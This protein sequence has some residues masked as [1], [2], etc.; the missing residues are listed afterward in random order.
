MM[1]AWLVGGAD[2]IQSDIERR[3]ADT[4]SYK[5][6]ALDDK[7]ALFLTTAVNNLAATHKTQFEHLRPLI[8][9]FISVGASIYEHHHTMDVS[10]KASML[11]LSDIELHSVDLGGA[12]IPAALA[13]A[14]RLCAQG[15][16]L[17]LIAGAE[18]PR[19]GPTG[20][21]YYR[22]ISDALLHKHTELHTHTNLISLYALMADR[23]IFEEGVTVDDV[24]AIT[25]YYRSAAVADPRAAVHGK[26]FREGELRR[27]LAGCYATPMVAVATDHG[28]A[29][30][31]ASDN[32]LKQLPTAGFALFSPLAIRGVGTNSAA[33]YLTQ[34]PNFTSPAGLAAER[35]FTR[36]GLTAGDIDYAWI[37]DCF[38]LMLVRQAAD[39]FDQ[40]AETVAQT[41][42]K[43]YLQ[44][45][46][47][48]IPVNSRGGI[49]NT[50]AAISLSAAS[51]LLDI[52][53]YARQNAEAQNFFFGG[54]G[55]IDTIN[56]VALLS[57]SGGI[58]T[59]GTVSRP[60]VPAECRAAVDGEE[61]RL[62]AAVMVR[63]NPGTDVPFALGA[64]RR[65]D[66]SLFLARMLD[67]A[68][69]TPSDT[70]RYPRDRALFHLRI[71]EAG[72]FAVAAP[73]QD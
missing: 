25:R 27:Y 45:G 32:M 2:A 61:A 8:T 21:A 70:D 13:T 17:V 4:Q 10:K 64:F 42:R 38:T 20:V 33:K 73:P 71:T 51:G 55:G 14:Q 59:A 34:R 24:E 43:G 11:G 6:L 28:A 72:V 52:L 47:K 40:K 68:G 9:D 53:D 5:K 15:D 65:N 7:L 66:G 12:S 18:V 23:M 35:A 37:Y 3:L 22:E 46:T 36:A 56:A 29:F 67:A 1:N 49:L 41:L 31:V 69:C 62:Y 54:N 30:L 58:P 48:K 57:R 50:Q 16:R 19:G 26:T 63:F 44:K 60:S 39:Y